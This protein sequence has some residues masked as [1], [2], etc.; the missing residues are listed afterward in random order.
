MDTLAPRRVLPDDGGNGHS[1]TRTRVFTS[2]TEGPRRGRDVSKPG[3]KELRSRPPRRNGKAVA[4]ARLP[5]PTHTERVS[6]G[7]SQM[8][9][10]AP[11]GHRRGVTCHGRPRTLAQSG[12]LFKKRQRNLPQDNP[13]FRSWIT[14]TRRASLRWEPRRTH[15]GFGSRRGGEGVSPASARPGGRQTRGR[16][17]LGSFRGPRRSLAPSAETRKGLC[18]PTGQPEGAGRREPSSGQ[19]QSRGERTLEQLKSDDSASPRRAKGAAGLP[20]RGGSP[21]RPACFSEC[22]FSE[23]SVFL[24]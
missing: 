13:K 19:W 11:G 20:S 8:A 16:W 4:V 17:S 21:A 22:P 23:S 15:G 2:S 3:R 24:P 5:A 10:K 14:A 9:G 6:T 1:R 7:R 12:L 18:E